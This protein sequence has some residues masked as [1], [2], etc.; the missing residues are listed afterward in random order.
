MSDASAYT[1]AGITQIAASR[2]PGPAASAFIASEIPMHAAFSARGRTALLPC[3]AS[4]TPSA[5]KMTAPTSGIPASSAATTVTCLAARTIV[6]W[7]SQLT[8]AAAAASTPS[9]TVA[10]RSHHP[11]CPGPCPPPG[12]TLTTRTP[13]RSGAAAKSDPVTPNGS[14]RLGRSL[15][16]AVIARPSVRRLRGLRD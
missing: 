10:L 16:N 6:Y 12:V 1:P 5:A 14:H 3:R 15:A 9:A 7:A 2:H 8:A 13:S 4:A 11:A